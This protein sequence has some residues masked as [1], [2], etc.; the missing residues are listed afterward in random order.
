MSD[1]S[2][3]FW[4]TISFL[5][6]ILWIYTLLR[7]RQASSMAS[8]SVPRYPGLTI[9]TE[10]VLK[11][12]L[13]LEELNEIWSQEELAESLGMPP[14]I[15]GRAV[16]ILVAFGWAKKSSQGDMHLTEKGIVRARELIRAHRLWERYLV[17]HEG[18]E[19]EAVHTEADHREHETT[20]EELERLDAKLGHPAWDP[21]GHIIPSPG[22]PIPYPASITLDDEALVGKRLQIVSLDD[23]PTELLAQLILMGL[24]P[25][26][27]IEVLERNQGYLKLRLNGDVILL[28]PSAARHVHVVPAP[29]LH[30][31]LGE[32]PVGSKAQVIEIKGGGKHQ[33]RMLDMGFVPG[34]AVTVI[35]K[36]PL[37]DPVEYRIKGSLV[38]LRREDAGTILVAELADG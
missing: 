21:H 19:L 4:P 15:A 1:F 28:A 27:N 37:G 20:S 32:L 26:L 14:S 36:A 17:D 6:T 10:D 7:Y 24:K 13:T 2:K 18:L 23:E 3:W 38:A 33:R 5:M 9:E 22:R 12:A 31:P 16:E 29:V 11:S 25:S 34:A 8:H 35:R 30:F